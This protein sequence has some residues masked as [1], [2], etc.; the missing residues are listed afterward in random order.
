M[1]RGGEES[2][3]LVPIA[4]GIFVACT[5]TGSNVPQTFALIKKKEQKK[6]SKQNF[7]P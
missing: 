7:T 6:F 1:E 2:F 4:I 3:A 5:H